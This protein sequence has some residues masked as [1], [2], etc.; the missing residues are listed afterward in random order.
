IVHKLSGS[1]P[2]PTRTRA[3]E[4]SRAGTISTLLGFA[5]YSRDLSQAWVDLLCFSLQLF[6]SLGEIGEIGTV[7]AVARAAKFSMATQRY[8]GR[9]KPSARRVA[10][11]SRAYW[12][13][14]SRC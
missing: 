7:V 12:P 14:I 3:I 6:S 11:T 10:G 8:H 4:P 5:L 2:T 9:A 13:R 1:L